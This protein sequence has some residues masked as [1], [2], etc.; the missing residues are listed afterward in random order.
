MMESC[1]WWEFPASK[2]SAEAEVLLQSYLHKLFST[3]VEAI[4]SA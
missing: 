1:R 4:D 2:A 3:I